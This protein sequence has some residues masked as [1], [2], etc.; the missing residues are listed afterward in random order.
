[1]MVS[2]GH[3]TASS[4]GCS[5]RF[6]HGV[7]SDEIEV[8]FEDSPRPSLLDWKEALLASSALS[9]RGLTHRWV[10]IL[11]DGVPIGELLT[12]E[13]SGSDSCVTSNPRLDGVEAEE[14]PTEVESVEPVAKNPESE[15]RQTERSAAFPKF[16]FDEHE[17]RVIALTVPDVVTD[18]RAALRKVEADWIEEYG[19]YLPVPTED[20]GVVQG[21]N[22]NETG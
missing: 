12:E 7:S 3:A 18:F 15:Q 4:T 22:E 14:E 5:G 1:M 9:G 13:R 19:E 16:D 20:V 10:D 8:V 6:L 2:P 17:Y 21:N 11:E